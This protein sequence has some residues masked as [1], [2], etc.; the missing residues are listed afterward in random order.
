MEMPMDQMEANASKACGLMR[1]MANESRLMILCQLSSR[2]MTVGELLEVIPLSQSALSQHLGML[3]RERIVKTKR[4]AQYVRY[5]LASGEAQ[6]M[7][8]ALYDLYC[9]P[10]AD[11]PKEVILGAMSHT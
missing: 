8:K 4:E 6:Y 10:N 11:I 3:R 5:S 2:E 9:N 1:S 7:I